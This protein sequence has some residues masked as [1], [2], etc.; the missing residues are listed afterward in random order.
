MCKCYTFNLLKRW[1]FGTIRTA[2]P[3]SNW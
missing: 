3:K 2:K 1:I